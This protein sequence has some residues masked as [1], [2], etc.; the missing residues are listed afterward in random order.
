MTRDTLCFSMYSLISMRII[1]FSSSK[2]NSASARASSVLPTPVGPRKMNEPI[3]RLVSESPARL[4]RT[5][6][7][8]RSSA[9]SWPTTRS[10]SRSS[11]CTSFCASPSSNRP[12]GMPVHLLTS[13]AMS[14]SS[15]SSFSIELFNLLLKLADFSD[16][17][18]FRLPARLSRAGIFF[19]R[20]QFLFDLLA[21]LLRVR[22]AFLQ[23]RLALNFQLH[24]APF[25]LVNFHGQGIDLHA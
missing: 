4:R 24:D 13:F 1:N 18:L 20:R 17:F 11:M 14:S 23:Q 12:V 6:F 22:I 9:S 7:D 5:A 2:R 10:R 3:G 19:Q 16:G 15:T 21:P 25:D 8:T